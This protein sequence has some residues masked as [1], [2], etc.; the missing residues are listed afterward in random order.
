LFT[1]QGGKPTAPQSTGTERSEKLNLQN[2]K[3]RTHKSSEAK[4]NINEKEAKYNE[5]KTAPIPGS[6]PGDRSCGGWTELDPGRAFWWV[7]VNGTPSPRKSENGPHQK[8]ADVHKTVLK[9]QKENCKRPVI[10]LVGKGKL[11]KK[12]GDP[13]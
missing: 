3:L 12:R 5:Q 13:Y 1:G 7:F 4:K 8:K 9:S 2:A 11:E 10:K 6:R